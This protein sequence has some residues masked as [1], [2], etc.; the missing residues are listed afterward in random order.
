MP[1]F[2]TKPPEPEPVKP[3]T[4]SVDDSPIVPTLTRQVCAR[5]N[6]NK[7]ID[8]FYPKPTPTG[9]D[10]VCKECI[11]SRRAEKDEIIRKSNLEDKI[12]Y[13]TDQI[14]MRIVA[15]RE[16]GDWAGRDRIIRSVRARYKLDYSEAEKIVNE[17]VKRLYDERPDNPPR[18]ERRLLLQRV[19]R[20]RENIFR[21]LER[22]HVIIDY[23]IFSVRD[24]KTGEVRKDQNG[25]PLTYKVPKKMRK[26][27][28]MEASLIRAYLEIEQLHVKICGLDRAGER[29]SIIGDIMEALHNAASGG[30][31]FN[32]EKGAGSI[33]KQIRSRPIA[34]LLDSTSKRL[35]SVEVELNEAGINSEEINGG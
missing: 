32:Y 33:A 19:N 24:P 18:I 17:A 4:K 23:D 13:V 21:M 22:K 30:A 11:K 3:D 25:K 15:P 7:P 2:A 16:K 10:T 29:D 27:R 34:E 31:G 6:R 26:M 20:M 1:S 12:E 8:E 5:C 35:K 9:Y 28:V 14:A